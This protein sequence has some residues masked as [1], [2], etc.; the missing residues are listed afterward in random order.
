MSQE[1]LS[2]AQRG[3][4]AGRH[5]SMHAVLPDDKALSAAELRALVESGCDWVWESDTQHRFTW[6][7]AGYEQ[8]TGIAAAKVLG[9]TR[10]DFLKHVSIDSDTVAAHRADLEAHRPFRDFVYELYDAR[11]DCRW[12]SSSGSPR[13]DAAGVFQG[14]RGVAR[15]VTRVM[16]GMDA[17]GRERDVAPQARVWSDL[18]VIQG[19][20]HAERMMAALNIFKDG[21]CYFDQD[22][23]LVLYNEAFTQFYSPVED[24][25]RPGATFTEI[26]DAGLSRDLWDLNGL[27]REDWRRRV[28]ARRSEAQVQSTFRFADGRWIMYRDQRTDDGGRIGIATDISQLKEKEAELERANV[29]NQQILG[30]LGVMLDQMPMGIVLLDSDLKIEVI[31]RTCAEIWGMPADVVLRVGDH[32]AALV[33]SNKEKTLPRASPEE[34]ENYLAWRIDEVRAGNV[35]RQFRRADGTTITYA[36]TR[37]SSGK[38]LVTYYDVTEMS[39][40][41]AEL[42]RA[43][44]Q[45]QLAEA[46]LDGLHDPVFAKDAEMRYVIANSAFARRLGLHP[47]DILGK[48][49][50]DVNPQERAEHYD[51][52]DWRVLETGEGYDGTDDAFIDGRPASFIMRTNPISLPGGK[53]YVGGFLF[54]VTELQ[55]KENELEQARR[56]LVNVLESLPAGVIIYDAEDR[57]VFAN[58]MFQASLPTLHT[59]WEQG[60]SRR[61]MLREIKK[62]GYYDTPDETPGTELSAEHIEAWLDQRLASYQQ[63]SSSYERRTL[64]GHW[65]KVDNRKLDDGTFIGVRVNITEIK[66]RE[67]ELRETTQQ[68]DL[69]RHVLDELPVAAFIKADDLTIEYVNKAWCDISGIAKEQ[70]VGHNDIELFAGA[71]AAGY[72]SDDSGVIRTGRFLETE[73]DVTHRDGTVRQLMTRKAR[74]IAA[75]GSVH[76]FG[77]STDVTDI[78]KREAQL[79]ES[80]RENELLGSL[81]DNVPVAI[82][83][84]RSDLTTHYVNKGWSNLTGIGKQDA[85]GKTDMEMFGANGEMFTE[86]DRLV[87]QTGETQEIPE[88]V[89]EP[90]GRVRYQIARKGKMIASDGSLY[91]IGSTTD[92]TELK[93]REIELEEARQRAELADRA[94]SEFLANMSH[95]IR[96]PM[97][98]VLGMAEL[99]S[100]SELTTKQRTFTDIIVKSGNALLTII[101]DILDF[102]KIDAGQLTLDPA[103]F[104]LAEAVDD[105]AALLSTR[106]KEKD[107]ELIVHFQ[108]GLR[109]DF[110][111]DVGR[112]RQIIT[113]LVGNAVKFTEAGHVLIDV[114]GEELDGSTRLK[115][116]VTDTG[117]GIPEDKLGLV[118]DKFSQV[119]ASSTRRHEGTGLGLAITAR[120]VHLMGGD[121][122]VDS[123]LGTGSTF[124]FAVELPNAESTAQEAIMPLDVTGARVLIVD[125]NATNRT[126]LSEQMRS[127]TFDSAAAESGVEAIEVL[128]AVTARGLSVDCIVLDFQMPGMNGAQVARIIRGTPE[129]ANTPIVMLTSVDHSQLNYRD[130]SIDA[131]IVKPA[132][133]SALLEAVVTAIQRR[134]TR[135]GHAAGLAPLLGEDATPRPENR[136]SETAAPPAEPSPAS[137]RHQVDILVAED[138]E[139]NQLVFTQILQETRLRFHIVGNGRLVVEAARRLQ[140]RMILMDVSMPEMNGLEATAMIRETE[141]MS[142][143]HVP[144]VGVTAHALKGDR[145]RCLQAGMDDYLPKPISPKALREKIDRWL[146]DSRATQR[147]V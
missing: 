51:A 129:I 85:I 101:N 139:V 61:D 121:I 118:F 58:K 87:L 38:R 117:I 70:A 119:D 53:R 124:W 17:S 114:A 52:I 16:R 12:I 103:P 48:R 100:K 73:E 132:R 34:W 36:V 127:W 64:D 138:N 110:V 97:N 142:G 141:A 35:N 27:E 113:N 92:V 25:I 106:V 104:N 68:N 55:R 24:V 107:L 109:E 140:P 80:L 137:S 131:H 130:L 13:F 91:L 57:L 19:E 49:A 50:G 6:L 120:L 23:R 39:N 74:L 2:S 20:T 128:K 60:I 94:K 116:G 54:D 31:N 32:F 29:S 102:S 111:G 10:F 47:R 77:S 69:L 125:D 43:L 96:T 134:H 15:N 30:D 146:D 7:S 37:L 46:V 72:A 133:S 122:G 108:Q 90:G 21:F 136:G 76:L 3:N 67:A 105:V 82:Y 79:R 22:D 143:E 66:Q 123:Q 84:K 83:A 81:V 1:G 65:W 89:I 75:D 93:Q 62:A 99:L 8:H 78:R 135:N 44:E 45:A 126:I 11:E 26:I 4:D 59:I 144:I 56:Y 63:A 115:I 147:A 42:A 5:R 98:G 41:E 33:H 40:R 145:E 14:Y 9:R 18:D 28:L 88:T 86:G 71:E 95:E 112:I